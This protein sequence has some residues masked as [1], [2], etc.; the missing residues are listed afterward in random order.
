MVKCGPFF[1]VQAELN[2]A[3]MKFGF[4]FVKFKY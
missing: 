2:I 3:L 4:K 1:A